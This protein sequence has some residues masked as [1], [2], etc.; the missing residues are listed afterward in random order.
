MA[1]HFLLVQLLLD[2]PFCILVINH[3]VHQALQFDALSIVKICSHHEAT[4]LI[5]FPLLIE[6]EGFL[7]LNS[8]SYQHH[9]NSIEIE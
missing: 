3:L 5:S 6:V 1:I 9:E 7:F 4:F 2:C 8:G